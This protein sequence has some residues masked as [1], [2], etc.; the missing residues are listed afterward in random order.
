MCIRMTFAVHTLIWRQFSWSHRH[1]LIPFMDLWVTK[2]LATKRNAHCSPIGK[3]NG[4]FIGSGC[5]WGW[6]VWFNLEEWERELEMENF[7]CWTR[8]LN[9]WTIQRKYP[10]IASN[11]MAKLCP[12]T[13]NTDAFTQIEKWSTQHLQAMS[14]CPIV[15]HTLLEQSQSTN[16]FQFI[17]AFSN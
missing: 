3:C 4:I 8:S 10:I 15:H 14:R 2:Q 13:T 17:F 1:T 11:E 6:G 12:T 5:G 7:V 9:K 16:V